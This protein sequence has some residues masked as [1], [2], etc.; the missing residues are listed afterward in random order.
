MQKKFFIAVACAVLWPFLV[1]TQKEASTAFRVGFYNVENLF[2][3]EDDP[4]GIDEE[5]LPTGKKEWTQERYSKK[6]N[7]LARVIEALKTPAILGLC[8]VEHAAV[9]EDL[10]NTSQLKKV[11]YE[12]VHYESPDM[13]GIDVAL[14]YDSDLF[15]LLEKDYIRIDFPLWLE[16]EKYTSRDIVY[17]KLRNKAG[18]LFHVFVNHWPSRRGGLELS[19]KRR[20][21]VAS[22]LKQALNAILLKDSGAN[23]IVMGDLNDEPSSRSVANVLGAASLEERD[24]LMLPAVL[25]NPFASIEAADQGSY[26]YRGDWNMLDHIIISGFDQTDQWQMKNFGVLKEDWML[27]VSKK[28]A[29]SPNKTYGGPRY[30]GGFSDHLPVFVD[31]EQR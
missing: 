7:S 15:K 30:Y 27:Y 12:L 10:A 23:I 14:L 31:F 17:A 5:F 2:D 8:E 4:I 18:E 19:E 1:Y 13:R 9:V 11:G 29:A 26:N 16:A 6:L 25:Y 20:L 3:T 28:G 24:S 21:W 22:H